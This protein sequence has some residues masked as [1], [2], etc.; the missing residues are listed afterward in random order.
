MGVVQIVT[1]R[2]KMYL[3]KIS[4]RELQSLMFCLNPQRRLLRSSWAVHLLTAYML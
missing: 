3:K 4:L 2:T 1:Q